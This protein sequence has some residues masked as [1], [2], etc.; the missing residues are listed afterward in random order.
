MDVG[1]PDRPQRHHLTPLTTH[2]DSSG[3]D[4]TDLS[5]LHLDC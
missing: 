5:N 1:H 3:V 2:R 4:A